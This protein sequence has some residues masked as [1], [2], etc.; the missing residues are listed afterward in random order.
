M[1]FQPVKAKLLAT[2]ML[3]SLGS[4]VA[5][6][7]DI[8]LSPATP[9]VSVGTDVSFN[10]IYNFSDVSLGGGLNVWYGDYSSA[11]PTHTFTNGNGLSFASFTYNPTLPANDTN[12][13]SFA[14]TS[15]SDHL[16]GIAFGSLDGLPTSGSVTIGTLVFHTN[17]VGN[18]YLTLNDNANAGGFVDTGNPAQQ[19]LYTYTGAVVQVTS[20]VPELDSVYLLISGMGA[21]LVRARRMQA[22]TAK[23]SI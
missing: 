9:S 16:D 1:C 10:L 3:C 4:G 8:S 21:L 17:H 6:A 14:P 11:V 13:F 22:T 5:Y 18:Y 20:A 19:L 15:T 12:F 2:I 7:N 23:H